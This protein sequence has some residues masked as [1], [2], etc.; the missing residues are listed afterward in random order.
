[1]NTRNKANVRNDVEM[2]RHWRNKVTSLIRLATSN[3]F[4][5]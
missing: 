4:K 5:Q 1:M 2:Y 3:Y